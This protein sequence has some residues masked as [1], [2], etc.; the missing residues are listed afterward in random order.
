MRMLATGSKHDLFPRNLL[1]IIRAR[2]YV[3]L[4]FERLE[5]RA[6]PN[7]KFTAWEFLGG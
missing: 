6:K 7:V 4:P 3:E 2:R 5:L 1:Q